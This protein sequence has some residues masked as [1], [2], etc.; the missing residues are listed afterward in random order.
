MNLTPNQERL[1]RFV[2][3]HTGPGIWTHLGDDA[4][5]DALFLAEE[6]LVEVNEAEDKYRLPV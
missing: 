6:G 5:P 1:L 2:I 3:N 4:R